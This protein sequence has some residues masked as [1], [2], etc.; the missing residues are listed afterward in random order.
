MMEDDVVFNAICNIIRNEFGY[1]GTITPSMTGAD[2]GFDSLDFIEL[3]MSLEDT[4]K[5]ELDFNDTDY[6][7]KQLADECRKKTQ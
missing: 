1:G 6:T 3:I 4:L 2:I 7:F 5:I